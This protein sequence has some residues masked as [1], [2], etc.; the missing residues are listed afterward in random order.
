M[1]QQDAQKRTNV[2]I[3]RVGLAGVRATFGVL[4]RV[5]PGPGAALAERIWCHVPALNGNARRDLRPG[6]GEAVPATVNGR[7]VLAEAWGEGPVVYVSSGWGGWRGQLGALV[8]PLVDAG[9]R[10]V[11]FDALSHGESDPGG[12][13]RKASTLSE[14]ANSLTAVVDAVGPAHAIVAHS[15]GCVSTA[16]AA[17]DGL[18]VRRLVFIAPMADPMPYIEDFSHI[19]GVGERVRV[20][21]IARLERRVERPLADFDVLRIGPHLNTPLLLIHDRGDR[22]TRFSDSEAIAAAWPAAE[23]M[24]TEG[25]GH[26]RILADPFVARHVAKF[27]AADR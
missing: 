3:S 9:F 23:L 17:S 14:F 7:R 25:L 20:G 22:E 19:L 10:T 2:R 12:M 4:E 16:L 26:R 11:L 27:L 21:M 13:G 6:P 24:A 18:A 5:A 1:P 8:P 15:A